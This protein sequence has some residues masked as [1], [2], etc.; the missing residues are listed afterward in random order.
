MHLCIDGLF[1]RFDLRAHGGCGVRDSASPRTVDAGG[2]LGV[3]YGSERE[4]GSLFVCTPLIIS[5]SK[6]SRTSKPT[7]ISRA[8]SRYARVEEAYGDAHGGRAVQALLQ[9]QPPQNVPRCVQVRA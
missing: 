1:S 5:H 6:S 9:D 2:L 3:R 4:R 8:P 7:A